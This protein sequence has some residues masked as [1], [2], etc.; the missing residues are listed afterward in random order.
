MGTCWVAWVCVEWVA[1]GE[2]SVVLHVSV[3][4]PVCTLVR[5]VAP[6]CCTPVFGAQ[7]RWEGVGPDHVGLEATAASGERSRLSVRGLVDRGAARRHGSRSNAAP[8]FQRT[9][10]QKQ[11]ARCTAPHTHLSTLIPKPKRVTTHTPTAHAP[12]THRTRTAY[13]SHTQQS[14]QS[15]RIREEVVAYKREI[16]TVCGEYYSSGDIQ[17]VADS[18]E[19]LGAA[20]SMAHYFVKVRVGVETAGYWWP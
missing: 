18:L 16:A 8:S 3:G 6:G 10:K 5:P 14:A 7:H 15:H 19:E 2:R 17:D 9:P 11:E 1:W 4:E 13:A 12:H 20:G